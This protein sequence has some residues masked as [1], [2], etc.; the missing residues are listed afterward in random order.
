MRT[1]RSCTDFTFKKTYQLKHSFFEILDPPNQQQ[2]FK[3]ESQPFSLPLPCSLI[4]QN[5]HFNHPVMYTG[6]SFKGEINYSKKKI[7]TE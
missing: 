1:E 6:H 5:E 7:T 2:N 4:F 3:H